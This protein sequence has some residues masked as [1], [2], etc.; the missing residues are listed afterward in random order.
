MKT[1]QNLFT[2]L[3][4]FSGCIGVSL[5][6]TAWK[7]EP[8]SEVK[9]TIKNAGISVDGK[10]KTFTADIKFD[11][12]HLDKSHIEGSIDVNSIDTGIGSRDKHLRSDDY[13]DVPKYPKITFKSEQ[14]FKYEGNYIA[15][16]K[17]TIKDVTKEILVPIHFTPK[18]GGKAHFKS[19]LLLNRIDYGVGGKSL[20]MSDELTATLEIEASKQ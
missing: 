13:F 5:A 1:L 4:I 20:M 15:R 17:L 7:A 11:P 19:T 3:C 10:F 8:T 6:Q 9:F 12:E 18:E 14:I 16:G 2:A